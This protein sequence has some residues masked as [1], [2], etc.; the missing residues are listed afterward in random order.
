MNRH[1]LSTFTYTI[2]VQ[3]QRF[4]AHGPNWAFYLVLQVYFIRAQPAPLFA[5]RLQPILSST[6]PVES[7]LDGPWSLKYLLLAFYGES[8]APAIQ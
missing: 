5:Y 1:T 7:R 8:W 3:S 2:H 6:G 4:E